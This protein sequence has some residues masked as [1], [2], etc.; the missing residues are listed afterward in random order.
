MLALDKIQGIFRI[1]TIHPVGSMYTK[2]HDN[3]TAD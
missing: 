1:A 2:F 3:P